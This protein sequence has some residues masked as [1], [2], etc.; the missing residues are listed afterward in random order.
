MMH[1]TSEALSELLDGGRVAGADEHLAGCPACREELRTLRGLRAELRDLPELEAPA[2]LWPAIAARLPYGSAKQRRKLGWPRLVV[3]QVAAM[4]A[5][6]VLGLGLGRMLQP[7]GSAPDGATDT[8][9][10]AQQPAPT[11][12]AEALEA[13]RQRGAEYDAALRNLERLAA[14]QGR[15]TPSLASERLASLNAM[16]E[17]S[18]T[19]LAS[20]PADPVLN[21]YLFAALEERDAVIREM[22][23]QQGSSSENRWR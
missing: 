21:A 16:V 15:E 8:R 6:F 11:S 3:L 12:L 7:N 4:A 1:L 13:V 2:E 23:A 17:A 5:V 14:E 20:D 9:L 22:S 10:V 19:A 18:R